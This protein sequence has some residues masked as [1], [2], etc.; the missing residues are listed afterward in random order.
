MTKKNSYKN[1]IQRHPNGRKVRSNKGKKRG[2]YKKKSLQLNKKLNK[3]VNKECYIIDVNNKKQILP[4]NYP[5]D[6]WIHQNLLKN[7]DLD[8]KY[9][10]QYH[11]ETLSDSYTKYHDM[12]YN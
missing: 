10:Q 7:R 6:E 12:C 1:K 2:Q 9:Y 11:P 4:H 8:L 3:K 5:G